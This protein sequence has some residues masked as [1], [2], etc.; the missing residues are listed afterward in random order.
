V[1]KRGVVVL[2]LHRSGTL[3]VTRVVSLL[4]PPLARSDDLY[5]VP[6]DPSGHCESVS[7]CATNEVVLGLFGGSDIWPP[8]LC[9]GWERSPKAQR[10]LLA[11]RAVFGDVYADATGAYGMWLW[12][13]PC[14]CL[15]LAIWRRLL[16]NFCV[17][18]VIRNA[19]DVADSL[20]RREGFPTM[21]CRTVWDCYN[22]SVL[23]A[24]AEPPVV[25]VDFDQMVRHPS[26]QTKRL[27]NGLDELGIPITGNPEVAADAVDSAFPRR[28]KRSVGDLL[29][30]KPLAVLGAPPARSSTF[31]TPRLIDQQNWTRPLFA[32]ARLWPEVET[33]RQ[34]ILS[35]ANNRGRQPGHER[36]LLSTVSIPVTEAH[37]RE[38]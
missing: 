4:G 6:D 15:T 20:H 14:L 1:R 11:M 22:R 8:P 28:A 27:A 16:D 9:S 2:G 10:I 23:G 30:D 35:G 18:L 21:Y 38:R 17:V 26:N 32:S 25:V 3:A 24:L 7:L 34:R 31:V 29:T 12:K 19:A 13:D 33:P 5:S 37:G 36:S